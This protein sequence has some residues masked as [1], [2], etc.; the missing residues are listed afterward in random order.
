MYVASFN[1]AES[2]YHIWLLF[3]VLSS[4]CMVNDML[5]DGKCKKDFLSFNV[6]Q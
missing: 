2:V 4:I 6:A 5:L 1:M 3:D